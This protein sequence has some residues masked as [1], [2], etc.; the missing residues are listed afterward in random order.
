M[1]FSITP[2]VSLDQRVNPRLVIGKAL[3]GDGLDSRNS[4]QTFL[5]PPL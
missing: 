3:L 1:K 5:P 2:S 4:Q